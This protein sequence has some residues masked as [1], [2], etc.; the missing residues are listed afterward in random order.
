MNAVA[1]IGARAR[2]DRRR[3]V[4][5]VAGSLALRECDEAFEE[6]VVN[7]R[8]RNEAFGGD[9]TLPGVLKARLH[10]S[11]GGAFD[12][13]VVEHDERVGTAEFEHA[14][15]QRRAGGGGDGDAGSFGAGER[16]RGDARI[17]DE[18]VDVGVVHQQRREKT[19]GRAGF[20]ED[21]LDL[22]PAARRVPRVLQEHRISG[23]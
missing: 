16:H 6:R 5:G 18:R 2:T 21:A 14:F 19:V 10:R 7:R 8:D 13:G 23:D 1:Q 3:L 9:A 11:F 17:R 20:T 4:G 15:F 12:V 22:Q